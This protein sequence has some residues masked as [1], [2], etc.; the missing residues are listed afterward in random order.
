MEEL[1]LYVTEI[2][3]EPKEGSDDGRTWAGPNVP[4]VSQDDAQRYCD[5][6]GLGYCRIL[7]EFIE[8]Q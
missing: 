1:K 4:G 7:G 6:N 3:A 2:I 8:E 5:E